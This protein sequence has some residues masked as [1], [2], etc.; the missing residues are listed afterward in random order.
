MF[1]YLNPWALFLAKDSRFDESRE[2]GKVT[3]WFERDNE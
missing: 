3:T 1:A 2:Y